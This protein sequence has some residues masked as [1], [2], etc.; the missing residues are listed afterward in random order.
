MTFNDSGLIYLGCC[1]ET[2]FKVLAYLCLG[3][4][5]QESECDEDAGEKIDFKVVF[6]KQKYDVTFPLDHTVAKLKI[7]IQTL[8]G[9][10]LHIHQVLD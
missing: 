9:K 2:K 6:N 8:T 1:R 5:V 4:G 3:V 7:H 10:L